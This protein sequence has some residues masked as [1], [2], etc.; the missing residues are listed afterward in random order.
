MG[1]LRAAALTSHT[2]AT[3]LRAVGVPT[4]IP[5]AAA[6]VPGREEESED[7]SSMTGHSRGTK[8]SG[9]TEEDEVSSNESRVKRQKVWDEYEEVTVVKEKGSGD[10]E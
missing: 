2:L 7:G 6:R 10:K 9:L 5:A 8:T 4:T 3:E 1:K